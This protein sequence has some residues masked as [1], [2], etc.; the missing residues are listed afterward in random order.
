MS[1]A[2]RSSLL[3][4]L[5]LSVLGSSAVLA[6][7]PTSASIRGKVL[8]ADGNALP[9]A[10]VTATHQPTGTQYTSISTS[11]G[12]FAMLNVRVGGPYTVTAL[13]EGFSTQ[14]L[15]DQFARLGETV[16]LEFRLPLATVSE[17]ITVTSS[18]ALINPSRTG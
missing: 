1:R 9:G 10:T 3:V 8:S 4:A 7:G 11:D 2:L 14:S 15:D 6:Q 12:T 13:L 5:A 16:T 17:T 18:S